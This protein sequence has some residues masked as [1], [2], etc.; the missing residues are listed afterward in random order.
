MRKVL[1]LTICFISVT[2]MGFG[3][4]G[5]IGPYADVIGEICDFKDINP[6]L[7]TVHIVHV[8]SGGSSASQFMVQTYGGASL[9][10][11]GE[12]SPFQ[13][14]L[15][16]SQIGVAIAYG[17]CML[18]PIHIMTIN[19][20][21]NG[22]SSDCSG[23]EIV[24]DPVLAVQEVLIADCADPPEILIA[25]GSRAVINNDGSCPCGPSEEHSSW[26]KIKSLYQE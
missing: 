4:T 9:T 21:G 16:N 7:I 24:P 2:K 26:G 20:F 14:I 11:V 19:Y 12:S 22:L 25:A 13:S 1:L 18:S 15:G 17:T 10:Y 3:Q 6:G 23:L 8:S 5:S